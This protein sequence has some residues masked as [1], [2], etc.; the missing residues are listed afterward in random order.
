M[1]KTEKLKQLPS[2]PEGQKAIKN[3]VQE[4]VDQM[5]IIQSAKELMKDIK[6]VATEKWDVDGGWLQ[7]QAAIKYDELYNENKRNEAILEKAEEVEM[8]KETFK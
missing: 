3:N 7:R 1:P 4:L 8:N 2:T 5:L 6:E